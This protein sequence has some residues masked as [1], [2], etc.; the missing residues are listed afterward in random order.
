MLPPR[1]HRACGGDGVDAGDV[2]WDGVQHCG[3]LIRKKPVGDREQAQL[4]AVG[5]H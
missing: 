2:G 3:V 5:H 4:M 1:D